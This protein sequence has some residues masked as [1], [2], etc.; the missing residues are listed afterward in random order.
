MPKQL[1]KQ[2][3]CRECN[4]LFFQIIYIDGKKKNLQRRKFCL[5]CSPYGLHNT[6]K[7]LKRVEYVSLRSLSGRDYSLRSAE[8]KRIFNQYTYMGQL[9]RAITRK[10]QLM[11]E[12][13]YKC[14][15]CGYNKC[16]EALE[17]HHK[18]PEEKTFNINRINLSC[19]SMDE[20]IAESK[21]CLLLCANCHRELHF[22]QKK[23]GNM[24]II[25]QD[26]KNKLSEQEYKMYFG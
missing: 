21:K 23:N 15:V 3:K 12:Y 20:C 22:A 2:L 25:Q 26:M 10:L 18:N 9:K 14:S 11:A 4:E 5:K 7:S 8:S 1:P 19:K 16:P 13:E 6:K 17:F 24:A